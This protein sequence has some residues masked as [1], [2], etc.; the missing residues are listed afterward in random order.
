MLESE[1]VGEVENG[2]LLLARKEGEYIA[3]GD[4]W[5]LKI[6]KIDGIHV[7]VALIG[8]G[9]A[10]HFTQF[11]GDKL[12]ISIPFAVVIKFSKV[13]SCEVKVAITAPR[14]IPIVRSGIK[15]RLN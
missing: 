6:V 4:T 2:R 8:P 3:I 13:R 10:M 14:T 12:G 1:N 9:V 7:D 5:I 15:K 11:E